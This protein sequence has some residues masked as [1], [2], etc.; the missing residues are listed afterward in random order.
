[1]TDTTKSVAVGLD[2]IAARKRLNP[3]LDRI[4][5]RLEVLDRMDGDQFTDE[6]EA[7]LRLPY[8]SDPVFVTETW[9]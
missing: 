3:S 7:P 1:M 5:Q 6:A 9:K 8:S 2:E 4:L